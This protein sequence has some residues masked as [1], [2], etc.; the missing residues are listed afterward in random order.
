MIDFNKI[1]L[2]Q[3]VHISQVIN[4]SSLFQEEFIKARYSRTMPNYQTTVEFLGMLNLVA[5]DDKA[6][7]IIKPRYKELLQD[8]QKSEEP[9]EVV[10]KCLLEHIYT[11][12]NEFAEYANRFLS[13]FSL[14]GEHYEFKPTLKQN[15]QYSGIRNFFMQLHILD[16]DSTDAKYIIEDYF[17]VERLASNEGHHV[18][19]K[20]LKKIQN[21]K[22]KIGRAA[23]EAVLEYEKARLSKFPR[24]ADKIEHIAIKDVS[25]GYDIKSYE[26]HEEGGFTPRLIEV[27]AVSSWDYHFYWTRNEIEASRLSSTDYYL[28]L[29]PVYS[30]NEF[31]LKNMKQIKDPFT[32]VYNNNKVWTPTIETISYAFSNEPEMKEAFDEA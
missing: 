19:E 9:T 6:T 23:E 7:I 27:K 13:N 1:S 30:K 12:R 26:R 4:G 2:N 5:V 11:V 31:D 28:Y 22:E 10:S 14:H 18:S 17:V 29:L 25:A 32:N 16:Y 21:M 15:L 20:N 24:V 8:I 3:I